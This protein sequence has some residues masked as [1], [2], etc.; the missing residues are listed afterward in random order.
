LASPALVRPEVQLVR[1]SGLNL[2]GQGLPILVALGTMPVVVRGLGPTQFGILALAW[3]IVGYAGAFDLGLGRAATKRVSEAVWAGDPLRVRRLAATAALAQGLFGTL[4]GA[5]LWLL[6]PVLARLLLAGSG[7]GVEAAGLLRVLAL[8]LPAVLLS[9]AYRAV[10]EGLNRFDLV[11]LGRAPAAAAMFLVPFAGV[12]LGWQL[13]TIVAGLVATRYAGAAW[14]LGLY[15]RAASWGRGGG[16]HAAELRD[17]LRFGGWIAVSNTII[18]LVVYLERFVIAALRGPSALAYYAAPHE[19]VSKLHLIPAAVAG[20]L[21]PAFSGLSSGGDDAGLLRRIRQGS[22]V[23]ALLLAPP[24][25]ILILTAAPLLTGW[26]GTDYGVH[27]ATVMRL[28]AF[29]LFLTGLAFVPFTLIEGVGRPDVV[30]KYHLLELPIYAAVLWVLVGQHGIVGAAAAWTLRMGIT[31]P[32]F[33]AISLRAAGVSARAA[34]S[35]SVARTLA[36]ALALLIGSGIL[37]MLLPPLYLLLA[38]VSLTGLFVAVAWLWLLEAEDRATL[39]ALGQRLR[40]PSD[41]QP[42]ATDG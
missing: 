22:R 42:L 2:L 37:S 31:A 18:P 12:L 15:M 8:A 11:N 25:A 27:S 14:F 20:V 36:A 32:L 9:N 38:A 35:G 5:L 40:T 24:V 29:A 34:L 6:A 30:A 1:N 10:L 16:I 19:L 41:M 33:C 17:L 39:R 3:T 4:T 28:L 23:I 13:T 7:T 21:F 26:L